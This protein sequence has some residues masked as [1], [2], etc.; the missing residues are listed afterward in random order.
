MPEKQDELSKYAG[1]LAESITAIFAEKEVP[2]S[3]PPALERK[4]ILEY[5]GRMRADG[6]EKFNCPTFVSVVNFFTS[7]K[8]MAKNNALGAVIVYIEQSFVKPIMKLL[9]YPAIDA[10]DMDA[11]RDSAGTLANIISGRFKS[12]LSLAGYIGLEMSHFMSYRNT[13]TSGIAFCF[14]EYD[15]YEIDIFIESEKRL[16]VELTMGPIPRAR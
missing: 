1:I 14:K 8:D 13:A 15:K 2:L 7:A 12:A 6:M 11:L 16:V 4:N 9:K 3:Q 5:K 10:E